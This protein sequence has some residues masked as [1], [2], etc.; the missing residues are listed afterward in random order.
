MKRWIT[1]LNEWADYPEIDAF[2]DELAEVYRKHGLCLSHEDDHGAFVVE[3]LTNLELGRLMAA[4]DNRPERPDL[5]GI[6]RKKVEGIERK[7]VK[8]EH[9]RKPGRR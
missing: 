2:L 6:E 1:R 8:P 7:K 3:P 4:F 9:R 5:K